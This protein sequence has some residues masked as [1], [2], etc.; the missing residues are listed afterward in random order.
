MPFS[1]QKARANDN[2]TEMCVRTEEAKENTHR[3]SGVIL[4]YVWVGIKRVPVAPGV[5]KLRGYPENAGPERPPSAVLRKVT[6]ASASW[7]ECLLRHDV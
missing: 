5:M 2:L 7:P 6:V 4:G 1:K 3:I